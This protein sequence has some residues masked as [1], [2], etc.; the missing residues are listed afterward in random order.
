MTD[1][2]REARRLQFQTAMEQMQND[3][4]SVRDKAVKQICG[5]LD[6]EAEREFQQDAGQAV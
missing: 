2:E 3:S 5:G 6:Q 1:A 4:Q